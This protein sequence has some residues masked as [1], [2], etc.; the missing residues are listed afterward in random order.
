MAP[1]KRLRFEVAGSKAIRPRQVTLTRS[2]QIGRVR[3][4]V[5]CAESLGGRTSRRAAPKPR[6]SPRKPLRDAKPS[7]GK[8]SPRPD[9]KAIDRSSLAKGGRTIRTP[10]LIGL[11]E[12]AKLL[13]LEGRFWCWD[14]RR[15]K[16]SH[17]PWPILAPPWGVFSKR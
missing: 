9:S 4:D 13:G 8:P 3:T 12:S 15:N 17:E 1:N 10:V 2:S 11:G 14:F 5:T 6:A 16:N 7:P